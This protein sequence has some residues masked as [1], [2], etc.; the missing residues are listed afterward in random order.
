MGPGDQSF[1]T[2][3]KQYIEDIDALRSRAARVEEL[4][5]ENAK[6]LAELESTKQQSKGRSTVEA[7]HACEGKGASNV[8]PRIELEARTVDVEQYNQ[9]KDL[10]IKRDSDYG[11]LVVA[12]QVLESKV[13]HY[14]D[15][16][17]EWREYTNRWIMKHPIKGIKS[18]ELEASKASP[19]ATTRELRYSSAPAPPSIPDNMTPSISNLSRDASPWADLERAPVRLGSNPPLSAGYLP[20]RIVATQRALN[21]GSRASSVDLTEVSDETGRRL[22]PSSTAHTHNSTEINC[23]YA[24]KQAE[25]DGSSPIIIS[26]RSLKRKR[27]VKMHEDDPRSKPPLVKNEL[28]SSS[29]LFAPSFLRHGG[30]H[31]S[32]DLDDVGGHIDTPRKRRR[33]EEL[34]HGSS[35]VAPA[36]V[37]D[38]E[39]MLDDPT[40]QNP[41]RLVL[42]K[43]ELDKRTV[44][45]VRPFS[46]N[47]A[48]DH[49]DQGN[50]EQGQKL[51]KTCSKAQQQEHNKRVGERLDAV[52][53]P[54]NGDAN[55]GKSNAARPLDRRNLWRPKSPTIRDYPTPATGD[56]VQP[57]ILQGGRE[58]EQQREAL[59]SPTIL[60]PTDP[61]A[62]VFPRTHEK[63][64]NQKTSCP[65]SRR[66][67]GAAHVPA[68]AEDGEDSPSF[69]NQGKVK[70]IDLKMSSD[71][72]SRAPDLH[73]R[74]GTLLSEPSPTKSFLVS[75]RDR[76]SPPKDKNLSLKAPV[77]ESNGYAG[78][79]APSTIPSMPA[80]MT[81]LGT[82]F[83]DRA[84]LK[85]YRSVG[86]EMSEG[87]KSVR[88]TN[89]NRTTKPLSRRSPVTDQSADTRP[90]HE[91]LRARP[92]HR[93]RIEDFK[94]NPAHS[95]YAYHE[96][97]RK[98]DEKKA[99]SGC[100]DRHCPRCRDIRIFVEN[101]G[102]ARVP[103]QDEEETDRRLLEAFLGN[104]KG[105]LRKMSAGEKQEILVQ[106]RSQ[107]FANEFGKHRTPFQ[108]AQSPVDYWNVGFPSTQEHEQNLEVVRM[109]E[110]EQVKAMYWEAIRE[111]GRYVF[112]DE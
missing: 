95:D 71:K 72:A 50:E 109:R 106:A 63:L 73:H 74:L 61:N 75:T 66:D 41:G 9:V 69:T 108:R 30:L 92:L 43:D 28:P 37:R 17:K 23:G 77:V 67:R 64:A 84:D 112:A 34:R 96:S 94:L 87:A 78:S 53:Q 15:I 44:S 80:Q 19:A 83:G 38:E 18:R 88:A 21:N 56:H 68:L 104:D 86:A 7:S 29:P 85:Q 99:L 40:N 60:Q 91:P 54:P 32:L 39:M 79:R 110:R 101:S 2:E 102:Y 8:P 49:K 27:P 10:L 1:A 25:N 107:Q 70:R 48:T 20:D 4:E 51:R 35:M 103:G 98:H 81:V 59:A 36:A 46:L 82:G 6:L 31:E 24:E 76:L 100:T 13:R 42:F 14:K 11:K 57:H 105:R 16:T 58:M 47:P 22:S 55:S 26:E 97:V 65:P 90:E 5:V 33:K 12:R 62:H 89:K 45:D 111:R 3:K 93:L 52:E